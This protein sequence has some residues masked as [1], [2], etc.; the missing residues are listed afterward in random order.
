MLVK[1]DGTLKSPLKKLMSVSVTEEL[2]SR[3]EAKPGDL[4]LL[5]SGSLHTVV[6]SRQ[7]EQ[8]EGLFLTPINPI[9]VHLPM[10]SA[11]V[12]RQSSPPGSTALRSSWPISPRP[13]CFQLPVGCGLPSFL[14][15]RRKTRGVGVSSSSF[16]CSAAR[17]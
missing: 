2:L 5:A 6:S 17:G 10:L 12:T 1:E 9:F 3:T 8:L 14:T 15:K 7:T 4:L 16:Y 11:P 13:C